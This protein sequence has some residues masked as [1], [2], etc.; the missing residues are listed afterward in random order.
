MHNESE[1]LKEIASTEIAG[2]LSTVGG[3]Q[4]SSPVE[5]SVHH[6]HADAIHHAGSS[7]KTVAYSPE[8]IASTAANVTCSGSGTFS[9]SPSV[10]RFLCIS[11]SLLPNVPKWMS[12]PQLVGNR[13]KICDQATVFLSSYFSP[14]A[15]ETG[16]GH[17]GEGSPGSTRGFSIFSE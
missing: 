12:N 11:P 1:R 16:N 6:G 10:P 14:A 5:C 8:R 13:E 17:C 9:S 3:H 4:A 7:S 2:Q 15:Q